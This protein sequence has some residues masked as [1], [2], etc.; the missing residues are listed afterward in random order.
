MKSSPR[1]Q[2]QC[3]AKRR[4][5]AAAELAV[6][7]PV[8][9]LIVLS[10][11]EA[12]TMVFLKQTL[13][14]AAYE[15]AR[16]ALAQNGTPASARQAAERV[17]TERRVKGGSVSV[18]PANFTALEPGQYFT[19]TATAP[20][21]GNSVIPIRFYRGRNLSGSATMMKEFRSQQ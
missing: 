13:S 15:G 2:I 1:N 16:V 8:I 6:C 9:V 10:T 3:G 12:C 19:V 17:L 14:I 21:S 4:G 20:A 7:L 18:T 5:V 11:I